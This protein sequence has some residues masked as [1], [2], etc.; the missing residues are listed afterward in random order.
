LERAG[1]YSAAASAFTAALA[2][3]STYVKASVSR[4]RVTSL[5]EDPS[6]PTVDL[7]AL[8]RSFALEVES[9]RKGTVRQAS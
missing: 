9:W 5:K 8:A 1:R 3:D 6:L 2:I 7:A 4:T